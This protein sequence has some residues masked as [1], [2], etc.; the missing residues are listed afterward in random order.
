MKGIIG[1]SFYLDVTLFCLCSP[2]QN[3]FGTSSLSVL[4]CTEW[5]LL[6][7]FLVL[8]VAGD[9]PVGEN[10]LFSKHFPRAELFLNCAE[11]FNIILLVI[12]I[13]KLITIHKFLCAFVCYF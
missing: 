11:S 10:R 5:V 8:Q 9:R 6:Q 3:R 4:G 13:F 2:V 7:P 1:S 12:P